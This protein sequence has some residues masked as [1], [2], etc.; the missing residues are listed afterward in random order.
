MNFADLANHRVKLKEN[1]KK[2][3]YRDLAWDV[4]KTVKYE[5]DDDTNCDWCS[6]H[7]HQRIDTGTGGLENKGASEDHLNYCITEI[8]QKSPGDLRRLT[9]VKNHQLKLM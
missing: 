6:W 9:S 4:K 1:K 3:K 2:D 8:G 7:G 5:S